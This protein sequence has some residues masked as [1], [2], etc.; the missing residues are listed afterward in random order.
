MSGIDET[1]TG[2]CEESGRS[3]IPIYR[4]QGSSNSNHGLLENGSMDMI[5][6]IVLY[7]HIC[8]HRLF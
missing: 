3:S 6:K 1:L 8:C 2:V 5:G 4:F 7:V